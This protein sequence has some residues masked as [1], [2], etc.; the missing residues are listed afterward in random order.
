[1]LGD[2]RGRGI[3][4]ARGGNAA[5]TPRPIYMLPATALAG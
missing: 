5:A 4:L 1:M 2:G 3:R